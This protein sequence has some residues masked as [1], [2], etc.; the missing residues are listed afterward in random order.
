MFGWTRSIHR[1]LGN[2]HNRNMILEEMGMGRS[3]GGGDAPPYSLENKMKAGPEER[4]AKQS[5]RGRKGRSNL[6]LG[7][8]K[9]G[10]PAKMPV[11]LLVHHCQTATN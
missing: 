11:Q 5:K 3:D 2:P 8:E 9:P 4:R 10:C 6:A 7:R 1:I